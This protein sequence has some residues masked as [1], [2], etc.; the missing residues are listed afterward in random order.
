MIT[1]ENHIGTIVV[2]RKYLT[3][4]VWNTVIG[5]F[6]VAGLNSG[7]LFEDVISVCTKK[8]TGNGVNII[9]KNNQLVINLNI[10]VVFGTNISA[11]VNSLRHRVS[12]AVEEATGIQVSKINISIDNIMS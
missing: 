9:T 1:R 7:S 8:T 2:S 5:S 3:E 12:Y 11:V 10:S 4:L 6:G